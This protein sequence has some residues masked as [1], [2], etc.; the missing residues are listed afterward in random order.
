[1]AMGTRKQREK[2]EDIC[3]IPSWLRLQSTGSSQRLN[4][5]L[6]E[7]GLDESVEGQWAQ[8]YAVR[9]GG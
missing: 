6:E 3:V 8:F 5:V 2:Q 7:E 4:K 9:N 1:M